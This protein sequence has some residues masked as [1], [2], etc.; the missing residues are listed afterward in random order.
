[1]TYATV[2]VMV[3]GALEDECDIH[4]Y[5]LLEE[6]ISSIG[7]EAIGHGYPTELFVLHHEHAN[8]GDECHCIQYAQDLRPTHVWNVTT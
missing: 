2:T 4:D 7:D 6:F 3:D 1:M 5:L 8:T